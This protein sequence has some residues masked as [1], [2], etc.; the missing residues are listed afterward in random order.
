MA[1]K[2]LHSHNREKPNRDHI[3]DESQRVLTVVSQF[4]GI[5][6]KTILADNRNA[7]GAKV[8]HIMAYL[9]IQI[10]G[11][12]L[13]EVAIFLGKQHHATVIHSIKNVSEMIEEDKKY[14]D[15]M[16]ALIKQLNS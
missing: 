8:R 6:K 15:D 3:Q 11:N 4:F 1:Y 5:S 9:L 7:I 16:V 14:R 12:V 2:I 13:T 10:E